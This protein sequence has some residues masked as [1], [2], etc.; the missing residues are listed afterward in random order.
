VWN[1]ASICAR[2]GA[3][4]AGLCVLLLSPVTS[5]GATNGRR[6][7]KPPTAPT[8]LSVIGST[9]TS[10]SL[11][12]S[13][14][15]DNVGVA[16][17]D[18][19]VNGGRVGKTGQ[20]NYTF[21]A[22]A[23]EK[24]YT[25][26]VDAYDSAGNRSAIASVIAAPPCG[27]NQ[28]P[29][30]PANLMLA[31]RTTSSLSLTW[32]AST[33][34]VGIAGYDVSEDGTRVGTVYSPGD[35]LTGLSCGTSYT[36]SVDAYD[37]AG[38]RSAE[39]TAPFAT[40]ACSVVQAPSTATS[41]CTKFADPSQNIGVFVAGLVSGDVGCLASGTYAGRIVFL[42]SNVTLQEA[43]GATAK[44]S[45]CEVEIKDPANNVTW[46]GIDVD[47]TGYAFNVIAFHIYGDDALVENSD[48]QNGLNICMMVGSD[49]YG[50]AYRPHV[51]H[52]RIHN[53]GANN[54]NYNEQAIYLSSSRDAVVEDDTIY[55][56]SDFGLITYD[57]AQGSLID[58]NIFSDAHNRS[59]ISLSSTDNGRGYCNTSN[60]NTISDNIITFNHDY[61]VADNPNECAL[62]TGNVVTHNCLW[63][64]GLGN[65]GSIGGFTASDNLVVDPLY[66]NRAAGNYS[67]QPNSPC[68]GY[69]PR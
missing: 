15:R 23:C 29:T 31:G 63:S 40:S 18:V 60:N 9:A 8:S 12:W 67:L 24:S 43:P 45:P 27:D 32:Q 47:A 48:I 14:S 38:N 55:N 33:D 64:N 26:G 37:A 2:Y 39:T 20:T 5:T 61:A 65:Y 28:A 3:F 58:H 36:V 17:Y 4:A 7:H 56:T 66:A 11:S 54:P 42:T 35:T 51:V 59:G 44:C 6:D 46:N 62:G 53:C 41:G 10:L 52:D 69:G 22:L 25:L 16:G 50:I 19:Y 34:N 49:T 30:A 13:A 68:A 1:A 57:N 21:T